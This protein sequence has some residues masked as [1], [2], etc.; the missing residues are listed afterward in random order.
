[1]TAVSYWRLATIAVVECDYMLHIARPAPPDGYLFAPTF[2]P[3]IA[4]EAV[5]IPAG[6]SIG[7]TREAALF[8]N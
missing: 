7:E 5:E 2:L 4:E 1:M 3:I 8:C 6:G